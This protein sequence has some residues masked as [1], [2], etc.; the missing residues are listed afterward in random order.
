IGLRGTPNMAHMAK[1]SFT[2]VGN[3]ADSPAP[4]LRPSPATG[5]AAEILDASDPYLG[6]DADTFPYHCLQRQIRSTALSR[7]MWTTCRSTPHPESSEVAMRVGRGVS[8][9]LYIVFVLLTC[10]ALSAQN[11][12]PR[13]RN[14]VLV[15]GAWADGSGWQGVYDILGKDGYRVSI[16]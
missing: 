7:L 10:C 14:I 13:V 3:S 12:A 11:A 1:A 2:S 15:H 5:H 8:Q 9:P 16:V 6:Y 4:P